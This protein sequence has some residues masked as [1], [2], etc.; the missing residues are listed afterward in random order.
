MRSELTKSSSTEGL[1][2]R[3]RLTFLCGYSGHYGAAQPWLNKAIALGLNGINDLNC[4]AFGLYV[5]GRYK[6]A[7]PLVRDVLAKRQKLLGEKH[8]QVAASLNN[9]A[10]LFESLGQYEEAQ[11]YLEQALASGLQRSARGPIFGRVTPSPS[12]KPTAVILLVNFGMQ[13]MSLRQRHPTFY[14]FFGAGF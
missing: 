6:E 3:L 12:P 10:L 1:G 2:S 8:P 4:A 7:K 9:L 13:A 5:G 11:P 14:F